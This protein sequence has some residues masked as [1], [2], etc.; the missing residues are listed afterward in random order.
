MA[1]FSC[2]YIRKF[3]VEELVDLTILLFG[4]AS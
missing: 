3:P 1:K 4:N 2:I